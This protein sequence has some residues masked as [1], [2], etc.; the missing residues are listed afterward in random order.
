MPLQ[1]NIF[2][3]CKSELKF[4]EAS[5]VGTLSVA[6]PTFTYADSIKDSTTGYLA[7]SFEWFDKLDSIIS[8]I[9]DRCS[10]IL[11][12]SYNDVEKKY[13]WYNQI[14]LIENVLLKNM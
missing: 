6:S 2:T 5:I 11:K 9:D 3:N 14:E 4:F 7:N 13:A 12:A 8:S 1:D 10:S